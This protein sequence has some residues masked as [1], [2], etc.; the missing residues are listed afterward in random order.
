[1]MEMIRM[2]G[3]TNQSV[4]YRERSGHLEEVTDHPVDTSGTRNNEETPRETVANRTSFETHNVK[5]TELQQATQNDMTQS[6]LNQMPLYSNPPQHS[7]THSTRPPSACC[8][9][10]AFNTIGHHS[11]VF[12]PQQPSGQHPF[13]TQGHQT[14]VVVPQHSDAQH[15]R[16][17]SGI[18]F[19]NGVPLPEPS[20]TT[21]QILEHQQQ[22]FNQMANIIGTTISKGF[23]MPRREYTTFDGNPLKY[24]SFMENF[25]TNVEDIDARRNFLIQLCSGKAKE[26]ISGMVMLP[27][28]EGIAEAKSILHEMFG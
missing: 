27:G 14:E 9:E 13:N 21:R 22:A 4:E 8:H 28:E 10:Q 1:M 18:H 19:F 2:K 12:I 17:H 16:H 23:E 6:H 3:R 11:P 25:K 24:P 26:A 15:I 7:P 20:T 5:P